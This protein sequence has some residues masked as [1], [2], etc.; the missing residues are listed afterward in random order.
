MALLQLTDFDDAKSDLDFIDTIRTST[1]DEEVSRLGEDFD[2]RIGRLKKNGFV[3]LVPGA[4]WAPGLDFTDYTQFLIYLDEVYVLNE[5][6]TPPVTTL[7]APDANFK[8]LESYVD[9]EIDNKGDSYNL[10]NLK[11]FTDLVFANQQDMED[12]ILIGGD[13]VDVVEGD[14]LKVA[15]EAGIYT[16]Y[17]VIDG[18]DIQPGDVAI[19]LTNGLYALEFVY[20]LNPEAG[21][22]LRKLNFD[23]DP[24]TILGGNVV[25]GNYSAELS[26]ISQLTGATLAQN[27]KVY[28]GPGGTNIILAF[29]TT[30]FEFEQYAITPGPTPPNWQAGV[31]APNGKIY[32]PPASGC[33]DIMVFDT[34]TGT[35]TTITGVGT[36]NDFYGGCLSDNGYIYCIGTANT[37]FVLKIN[38]IDDTYVLIA[39]PNDP[40]D[41]YTNESWVGQTIAGNGKIYAAPGLSDFF[42]EFDPN[43]DSTTYF[44]SHTTSGTGEVFSDMVLGK[45]GLLYAFPAKLEYIYQI[46]PNTLSVNQTYLQL[47]L[48]TT[49]K[50]DSACAA[51]NG[52]IYA[53]PGITNTGVGVLE[54]DIDKTEARRITFSGTSGTFQGLAQGDNGIMVSKSNAGYAIIIKNAFGDEAWTKS[55]YVAKNS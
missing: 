26:G 45:D 50:C 25:T 35:N 34:N 22:P 53:L 47:E 49:P 8:M 29:S 5:T 3:A 28:F 30:T 37:Q 38:P 6:V 16:T 1:N 7:A 51:S 43:T 42:I 32:F 24:M 40:G 23:N 17:K 21:N 46:D 13:T 11:K 41:G 18:G 36:G 55:A 12:L 52:K 33:G 9:S 44:G 20:A 2:T 27:G 10:T 15:D 4:A 19:L 31:L 14:F 39:K 54:L 48:G